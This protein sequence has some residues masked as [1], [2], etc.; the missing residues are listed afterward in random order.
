MVVRRRGRGGEQRGRRE[1]GDDGGGTG[2][3]VAHRAPSSGVPLPT[4]RPSRRSRNIGG[5]AGVGPGMPD[6]RT[7]PAARHVPHAVRRRPAARRRPRPADRAGRARPR[8]AAGPPVPTPLPGRLDAAVVVAAPTSRVRVAP[9]VANLPL[10]PPAVLARSAASLDLLSGGRVELGLGAGAFWDAIEANGGPRRT[11]GEAR[12]G[13]RGG[14][15]GD[16]RALGTVRRRAARRRALPAPRRQGRSGARARHRRSGWA[17]TSRGCCGSWAGWP[18]AGCRAPATS[19]PTQLRRDEPGDRR[20][21]GRGRARPCGDPPALQHRRVLRRRPD[22]GR[23]RSRRGSA[24]SSS[25]RTTRTPSAGSPRSPRR[26][27]RPCAA[28]A[29]D[30]AALRRGGAQPPPRRARAGRGPRCAARGAR[31]RAH[32]GRRHPAQHHHAVG[33]VDP[34]DRPGAGARPRLH[35]TTSRPAGS[36]SSTSTTTCAASWRRCGRWSTRSR[37]AGSRPAPPAVAPQRDD[38]AAER[39]DARRLLPVVLPGRH[40]RTTRSRTRRCCRTSPRRPRLAPVV[41]RLEAEHRVIHDV[42]EG[43]DAALVEMVR[44]GR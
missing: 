8:D 18:T 21:R 14:D 35:P 13:A 16:P 6:L 19:R 40:R 17:R 34:A 11:P 15:R 28:A 10:R 25:P 43:V 37:P 2:H 20:G 12:R 4:G 32:A 3:G 36:T 22:R 42:L 31:R 29:P 1:H 26:C 38:D 33:R 27:A 44:D 24:A 39:L 23:W 7:R 41:D 9:N 30:L 5:P